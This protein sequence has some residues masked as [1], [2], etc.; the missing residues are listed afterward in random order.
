MFRWLERRMEVL[1]GADWRETAKGE[2]GKEEKHRGQTTH[3]RVSN[4]KDQ[5]PLKG[6]VYVSVSRHSTT[7]STR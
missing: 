4:L 5:E 1:G 3:G 2:A 6:H 7:Q